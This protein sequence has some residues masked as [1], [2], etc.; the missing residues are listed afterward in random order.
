MMDQRTRIALQRQLAHEALAKLKC[1]TEL[2]GVEH[3]PP[4]QFRDDPP[5]YHDIWAAKV[6]E[7]ER[8]IFEESPIA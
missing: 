8:W 1:A 6:E 2:F 4:H 3:T 5:E 7:L